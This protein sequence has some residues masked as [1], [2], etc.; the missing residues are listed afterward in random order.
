MRAALLCLLLAGC[1]TVSQVRVACLGPDPVAPVL[2]AATTPQDKAA[3]VQDYA[4]EMRA[5]VA[6]LKAQMAGCL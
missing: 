5:Y 1:G 4:A 2:R 3:A 6:Q